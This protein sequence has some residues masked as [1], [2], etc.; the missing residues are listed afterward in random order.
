M[1]RYIDISVPVSSRTTVYPG[2]PSPEVSWPNWTRAKGDPASVGFFSGGLHHGTHVDAPWHFV[3]G[4][5]LDEIPL[6]RWLGPC[7]VADLSAETDCVSAAAL[8]N[9]GIPLGTKRL[10]LKTRNSQD[11]YWHQPWNPNFIYIDRSA[12]EWCVQQGVFTVGLDYLTI[13]PPHET[14]FPAHRTL[15]GNGVVLIEYLNLRHVSAGPYELIAAPINVAQADGA[16]CRA[17]LYTE[18]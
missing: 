1:G 10:L 2:D 13:D 17:L 11:D 16:W 6:D 9:A 18:W 3:D 14:T 4:P 15:L 5:T 8:Q 12:A 7:W